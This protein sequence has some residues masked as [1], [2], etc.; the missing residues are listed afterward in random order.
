MANP[1]AAV[2]VLEVVALRL[3]GPYVGITLQTSS[4]VI[5]VLALVP[6]LGRPVEEAAGM[7]KARRSLARALLAERRK[8]R[9]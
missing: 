3:V 1:I 4:A 2:L 7:L 5:G 8:E 6:R 9:Q